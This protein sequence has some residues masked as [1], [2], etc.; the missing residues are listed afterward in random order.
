LPNLATNEKG[1]SFGTKGSSVSFWSGALDIEKLKA[2]SA[3]RVKSSKSFDLVKE[4]AQRLKKLEEE[5]I[6]YLSEGKFKKQQEENQALSKKMEELDKMTTLLD[7]DNLSDD[8]PV[9]AA[10]TARAER[11]KTWLRLL[12]KDI[13]LGEAVNILK[14]MSSKK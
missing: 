4:N 2:K 14:D 11:N 3:S 12:K 5:N 9:I 10:D 7:I 8:K 6:V 1:S 13:I